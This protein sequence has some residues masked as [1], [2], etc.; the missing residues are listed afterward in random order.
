[1]DG[2]KRNTLITASEKAI[3]MLENKIKSCAQDKLLECCIIDAQSCF[4]L[5]ND[6]YW[7][8]VEMYLKYH[9]SIM[10]EK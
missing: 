9:Y 1:M 2:K 5:S 3:M 7:K 4:N 8:N 10:Y 6:T